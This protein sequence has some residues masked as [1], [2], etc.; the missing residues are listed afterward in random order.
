MRNVQTGFNVFMKIQTVAARD[1]SDQQQGPDGGH[2]REVHPGGSSEEGGPGAQSQMR[3]V[4]PRP[5]RAGPRHRRVALQICRVSGSSLAPH[6][7]QCTQ[8]HLR[9]GKKKMSLNFDF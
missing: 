7:S 1:S 6:T 5:V 8:V 3:G 2:Q 9:K 4:D